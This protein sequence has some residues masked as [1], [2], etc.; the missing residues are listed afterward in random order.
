MK[1]PQTVDLKQLASQKQAV[2][3]PDEA[4]SIIYHD[5]FDYPLTSA[6]L[7]KWATG[8]K[9]NI[10]IKETDLFV[11][12]KGVFY[13][14]GREGLYFKKTMRK[15]SSKKKMKT[16]KKAAEF[17]S[18]I[19]TI[20]AIAV[21]GALSM[22]NA[23]EDSDID[24]MIITQKNTLWFSRAVS[25][26]LLKLF[27]F[28]V[29]R[30]GQKDEKDRLCLNIWLDETK[31]AWNIKK[32]NIYTAHEIAQAKPL[33]NKNGSFDTFLKANSWVKDYWPNAV[34]TRGEV[35][36]KNY[37]SSI[38]SYLEP[39][40]RALQLKYMEKKRTREVVGRNIAL[41]H[42]IDWSGLVLTKLKTS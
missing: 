12:K 18:K 19:P 7:I 9:V 39:F 5:I 31:L 36:S 6:E 17:L 34:Q 14:A 35:K 10:Q 24:L 2:L 23:D 25:L 4:T 29:R 22:N 33:I 11:Y 20:K 13:L 1:Y 37:T 41:F 32:R 15:R 38:F 26:V 28:K 40:A 3:D 42:P 8:E 16:A 21:T 30:F 27:G